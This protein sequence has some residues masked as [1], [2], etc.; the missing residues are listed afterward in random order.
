MTTLGMKSQGQ[1]PLEIAALPR[2]VAERFGFSS[3]EQVR[4][5]LSSAGPRLAELWQ[6]HEG[7]EEGYYRRKDVGEA[8]ILD[9]ANWHMRRNV[10]GLLMGWCEEM[11]NQGLKVLD[12][13]SGIGTAALMLSDG[14]EVDCLEPNKTLRGFIEWRA[15]RLGREINFVN[16]NTPAGRYDLALCI[17]VLEHLTSPEKAAQ[18]I[19]AALRPGGLLFTESDFTNDDGKNP[20]HHVDNSDKLGSHFWNDV[21]LERVSTYWWRKPEESLG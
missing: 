14:N 13:G 9:L 20:M 1:V 21:G 10:A 15:Q 7:S 3:V 16:G 17:D 8:Y 4:E 19:Y 18:A 12:Y 5:A 6:G 11:R 2:D